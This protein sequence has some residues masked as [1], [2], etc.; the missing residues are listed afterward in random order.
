M[1]SYEST[2]LIPFETFNKVISRQDH[3]MY[4]YI[5]ISWNGSN[6]DERQMYILYN[7]I[8]L[9]KHC[10][11]EIVK[12]SGKMAWYNG[13]YIMY[14]FVDDGCLIKFGIVEFSQMNNV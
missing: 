12:Y 2:I 13:R 5:P 3:T 4:L 14:I 10:W 9:N 8:V 6:G 1:C 7:V 11:C